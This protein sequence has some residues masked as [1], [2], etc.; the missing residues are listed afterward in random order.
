MKELRIMSPNYTPRAHGLADIWGV[1]I[2]WTATAKIVSAVNVANYFKN[3]ASKVSAHCVIDRDGTVVRC[4]DRKNA[5]WHAGTARYDFNRDHEISEEERHVNSHTIGYE[6]CHL[7]PTEKYWPEKQIQSLAACIRR[8]N[9]ACPNLKLR[10]ITD[11]QAVSLSGKIDVNKDF[12]ADLLFWYILHPGQEP[13]PSIY[14][15][16]PEWAKRQ[17]T[18]I[19]K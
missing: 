17:V 15:R 11:H 5:A 10:N 12:P 3:P 9:V 6:L 8:D 4:V 13:F 7:G 14:S 18:E 2:H 1:I 16:L 19:G